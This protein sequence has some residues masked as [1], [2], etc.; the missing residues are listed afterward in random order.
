[1]G[2]IVEPREYVSAVAGRIIRVPSG[3]HAFVPAALPPVLAYDDHLVVLL[4]KADAVLSELS[5]LGRTL[6]NPHLL[7][8]PYIRREA[9]LSS[10]I[11]GTKTGMSELM[12]DEVSPGKGEADD[13]EEVRNYVKA[14]QHGIR[15][16]KTLP[17]SLRLVKEI[18]E[19]LMRGVRGDH[20]TPGEFRRSQNWIGG[21]GST[22]STARYVP[23]PV[24]EMTAALGAWESFMH[25]RDRLPD[26][27]QCAM[28]HEHFEAIHPFLD[29]NG[30]VGRLLI[31]LFLMERGRLSQ[32]LLYLSAFFESHRSEYYEHLMR[33]RTHGAW[34]EW[35]A[36]FLTGVLETA[37]EAVHRAGQL[38]DLREKV[39]G[40]LGARGSALMLLDKLFE[41]PYITAAR[42]QQLLGTSNP[43][44]RKAITD[45]VSV[46][47][48]TKL[49]EK[50]WGQTF[51]AKPILRII[52]EGRG[53]RP[54]G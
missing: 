27:V 1:M 28:I 33:I 9:V 35:V 18:H 53:T 36:F 43:T 19:V 17:L 49:Q 41:N 38:L 40:K 30:R 21:A 16:L 42:A 2:E 6:P 11:E 39:R 3:F 54:N 12:L 32:P 20:A 37:T 31:T 50:S 47:L 5:G 23:P 26:L 44:A 34:K 8:E 22:I 52:D 10:R 51:V 14:L 25:V 46:K 24:E 45:L 15:R 7:I 48:L 29:G 4:S 13:V